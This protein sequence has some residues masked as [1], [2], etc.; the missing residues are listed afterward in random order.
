MRVRGEKNFKICEKTGGPAF[1]SQGEEGEVWRLLSI[2]RRGQDQQYQKD[3][4]V[5]GGGK[6]PPTKKEK[7]KNLL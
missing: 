5:P 3:R 1:K 7:K 4:D 6:P 2:R